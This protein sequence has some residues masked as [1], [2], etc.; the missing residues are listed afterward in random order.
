MLADAPRI[1][2]LGSLNM[3][4]V[5]S[6]PRLPG[7]GETILG[8]PFETHPGGKGANQAVAAARLGAAVTMIGCVGDDEHGHRMRTILAADGVDASRVIVRSGIGTGLALI[9]IGDSGENTIVVVPRANTTL[10]PDDLAGHRDP[11]AQADVL[12]MQLETPLETVAAAAALAREAGTTVILN[13]APAVRLPADLMSQIDLVVVNEGEAAVLTGSDG[14]D[15]TALLARL[16]ALPVGTVVLTLGERGSWFSHERSPNR[17]AAYQIDPIDTV[18]AGDAFVGALATRWGEHQVSGGRRG[19]DSMA[20]L[21]AICWANAAGALA[22]T[23][24]GAIPSLPTRAEV[25][26]LL[27]REAR[28]AATPG[29]QAESAAP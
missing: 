2:V 25:L 12:L 19:V 28:S 17:L 24:R 9:T 5:V 10:T 15:E 22:C 23:R 8:G 21:D 27:R 1:C 7:A 26:D 29:A 13:A 11:I 16:A 4:L 20:M 3:D 14:S 18:G 6:S